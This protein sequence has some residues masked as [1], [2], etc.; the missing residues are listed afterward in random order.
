M[1]GKGIMTTRLGE[2]SVRL[3]LAAGCF[4]ALSACSAQEQTEL[5]AGMT[6]QM[7]VPKELNSVGIAVQSGGR[8]IFCDSYPVADG[9][10]TLPS[11]LGLQPDG[12]KSTP[13]TLSVLGFKTPQPNF[14]GDCLVKLPDV[15]ESDV[16]VI[17]RRRTPYIADRVLYLPMPLKHACTEQ[18]CGE[19]QT[20]IGGECKTQDI[21]PATLPEFRESLIYGNT[22]TCFSV[23]SCM[24]EYASIPASLVDGSHC[25]F[26]LITPGD[27]PL[28]IVAGLNV[29]IMHENFTPE[30]LDQDPD[31]GF[32]IDDPSNPTEFRLATSLCESRYKTGKILGVWGSTMCPSKATYQPL[33]DEDA[34]TIMSGEYS[35]FGPSTCV[36]GQRLRP[37][38]SALYVLMD[39]SKSMADFF[40]EKGL[41][42]VLDLSLQDPVFERTYV[43]FKFMPATPAD[44][45][46]TET[47]PN[48]FASLAAPGDVPF[49][50]ALDARSAVASKIGDTANLLSTDPELY[51]DA[52]MGPGGAYAALENLQPTAPSTAFN[53]RALLIL[54][55]RDLW[56]HCGGQSPQELAAAALAKD[57]HTY[58]V[59]LRAPAGADQ[60]GRDPVADASAIAAAGGT[61]LFDATS[62][63]DVG[64]LALA[65]IVTDL[66]SCVYDQPE[67]MSLASAKQSTT[68]SYFDP[69]TQTK[70]VVPYDAACSD[71]STGGSGWNLD[72]EGR[73]RV[74]G[75][76]CDSLRSTI[77]T[78]AIAAAQLSLPHPMIPI[79]ANPPCGT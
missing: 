64:A 51:L 29:R 76:S 41:Q 73:V 48:A 70:V 47:S 23:S 57:I 9:E 35:P 32:V 50:L 44:C 10:V 14:S 46:A 67:G 12:D 28:P 59:A 34:R 61:E 7:Q 36:K 38:E 55:N 72:S 75:A 79:Y 58:V 17:R 16:S 31:E 25:R 43:G 71:S 24:P 77:K 66:G 26:R 22:N 37:T 62:N 13:I 1:Q 40:G 6:T 63:P 52:V 39:R 42:E 49:T 3:S 68:L 69:V 8:L 53:R 65:T 15:G 11:T 5:V 54:G 74:C 4:S 45:T 78:S 2:W 30:I 27:T 21:D 19:G 56:S 18:S 60:A 20:C 33:C